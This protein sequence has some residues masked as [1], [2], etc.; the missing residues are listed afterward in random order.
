[1][2]TVGM[3]GHGFTFPVEC[4]VPV[5][6]SSMV[7]TIFYRTRR[8]LFRLCPFMDIVVFRFINLWFIHRIDTGLVSILWFIVRSLAHN[9]YKVWIRINSVYQRYY[10]YTMVNLCED[11]AWIWIMNMNIKY[12]TKLKLNS[13]FCRKIKSKR[14][15]LN[16]CQGPDHGQDSANIFRLVDW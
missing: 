9:I 1:M 16:C 6:F 11:S 14:R 3:P 5:I 4:I 7:G 12:L 10:S 2:T 13:R 8:E 15:A